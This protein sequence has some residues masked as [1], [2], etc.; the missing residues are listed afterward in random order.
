MCQIIPL[1]FFA[2]VGILNQGVSWPPNWSF[3]LLQIL[4]GEA[5]AADDRSHR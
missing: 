5:F 4:R 1:P 2:E 3:G